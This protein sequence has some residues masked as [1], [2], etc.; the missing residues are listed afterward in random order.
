MQYAFV[1]GRRTEAQRGVRGTCPDCDAAM[2]AKCGPR[3]IH[4][5]AHA[6]RRNCDPWWENE[7][8]WHREWK[9]WFPEEWR[10]VSHT[11]PDGEVHRADIKTPTGIF[12]EVQHSTMTDEERESFYRNLV[13]I[14]DGRKFRKSFHLGCMLPEPSAEWVKDIVWDQCERSA[15]RYSTEPIGDCV[16][17]FWRISDLARE[18]PGLTKANWY[19]RLPAGTMVLCHPSH[20]VEAESRADY[21]GHHQF[22]WAHPRKTWLDAMCPVYIDFGEELLYRL[23]EYD[24]TRMLC[25]RLVAKRK[26]IHDA[27]VEKR[28][29]DIAT[30]FYPIL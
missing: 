6:S 5:W 22:H 12:I 26:L 4:H 19:E 14:L 8:D 15:Y 21:R 28:A 29:E 10:E 9:D 17:S 13:W 7:T 27:M 30:R 25:V 1:N 3:M 16:P 23:Q 11:A 20:E 18:Y 2:V 24:E